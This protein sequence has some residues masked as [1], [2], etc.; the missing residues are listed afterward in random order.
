MRVNPSNTD[1]HSRS[2]KDAPGLSDLQFLGFAERALVR[3][4]VQQLRAAGAR[5]DSVPREDPQMSGDHDR[6]KPGSE[7]KSPQQHDRDDDPASD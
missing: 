1:F 5:I 4:E 2:F 3:P 6:D 7:N